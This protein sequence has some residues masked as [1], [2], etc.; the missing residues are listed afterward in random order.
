MQVVKIS[1]TKTVYRIVIVIYNFIFLHL[2]RCPQCSYLRHKILQ[3]ID[4]CE[5]LPLE[6]AI[7]TIFCFVYCT[8]AKKRFVRQ[9]IFYLSRILTAI[10]YPYTVCFEY[11]SDNRKY[12]TSSL[13]CV[14]NVCTRSS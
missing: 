11:S 1:C 12:N 7:Q 4:E 5:C 13:H 10:S 3:I 6:D 14:D 9:A 2:Y 8:M